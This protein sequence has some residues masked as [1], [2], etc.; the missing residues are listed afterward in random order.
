VS[1]QSVPRYGV[2]DRWDVVESATLRPERLLAV[3]VCKRSRRL[4]MPP[5]VLARADEVIEQE[6]FAAIA[7]HR[8]TFA[9]PDDQVLVA[10][11]RPR[12]LLL[13]PQFMSFRQYDDNSF[14]P[15]RQDLA[16]FSA[17]RIDDQFHVKLSPPNSCQIVSRGALDDLNADLWMM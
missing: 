4:E 13:A 6:C 3:H 5:T 10:K 14:L 2:R 9:L 7:E 11:I 1:A 8:I 16:T 17:G 12:D 15:E